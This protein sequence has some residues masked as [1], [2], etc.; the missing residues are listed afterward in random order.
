MKSSLPVQAVSLSGKQKTKLSI[1]I[2]LQQFAQLKM[3]KYEFTCNY[4]LMSLSRVE[5]FLLLLLPC[6]ALLLIDQK[7]FFMKKC[8]LSLD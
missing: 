3:C 6:P 8:Y 2:S 4:S 5:Q 1:K 7:Y